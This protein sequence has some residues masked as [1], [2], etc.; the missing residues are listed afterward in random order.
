[1]DGIKKTVGIIF[2]VALAA[3]GTVAIG[4]VAFKRGEP[5]NS[6]WLVVAGACCCSIGY[7]FYS[8]WI[9][10]KV[11]MIDYER[12]APSSAKEDG[13]DFIPTNKWIVFGSHFAAIAGPGPLVGPVLASQFGYLPGTLWIL[14]GAVLGGAVHDMVIM[15]CSVRRGGKSLSQMVKDEIG[16]VA[17][18]VAFASVLSILVI[19]IAVLSFVVVK[20]LAHSSWSLFTV[21]ATI[22][23]AVAMGS[24]LRFLCPSHIKTVTVLG[25]V[26]LLSAVWGGEYV[27]THSP[28]KDWFTWTEQGMAWVLIVYGLAASALP[29]WLLVTPRGY[30]SSF[31]KIGTVGLLAIAVLIIAPELKMPAITQFIDGT[32]PVLSGTVFPFCFITIACGAISGFHATVSTGTTPKLLEQESQVR[33]VGYG[34]MVTETMVAIMALIAATSLDP[35][36]Y[37]CMNTSGTPEAIVKQIS[38]LGFPASVDK[39]DMVAKDLGEHTMFGRVGGA[40]TF[41]VGMAHMFAGIFKKLFTGTE[42]M[43]L[44]YH[45]AIMFEALFILTTVDTGTRVGRFLTQELLGM[46]NKSL[47]SNGTLLSTGISSLIFVSAWGWFLIQGVNDPNGVSTLWAIFG[48]SNQLLAVIA[49]AF[50]ATILV[51]MG[52]ARYAWI[53]WG[54]LVWLFSVTMTAGWMKIFSADPRVGFLSQADVLQK[55]ISAGVMLAPNGSS[56]ATQLFNCYIDIALTAGFMV[57]V[58]VIIGICA[59]QCFEFVTGRKTP[60]LH[61]DD[62]GKITA[63]A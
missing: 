62:Y 13:K 34:A 50:G 38:S 30:L 35:D 49:L 39:M 21:A 11:L 27:S 45:F 14:I 6:L 44:W 47:G 18:G 55:K 60:V 41:A 53:C 4:V 40:P 31:M 8:S 58:L 3:I 5:V 48:I 37:F 25:V 12:R 16:P 61:E 51:K 36:V 2:W 59:W 54:P 7:R 57:M 63:A 23:I 56:N 9:A 26:A 1:M 19:I 10:A 22:P 29:M 28:W 33:L 42:A 20:A 43:A 52:R 15:F 32:G 17:G 46:A 24:S